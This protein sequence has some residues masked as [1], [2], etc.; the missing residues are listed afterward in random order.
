MCATHAVRVNA[1]TESALNVIK[2]AGSS[3]NFFSKNLKNW[4]QHFCGVLPFRFGV[5]NRGQRAPKV[6]P[7]LGSAQL[8][9]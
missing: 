8:K 2:R 6:V 1:C 9:C 5:R 7:V 3:E 4:T